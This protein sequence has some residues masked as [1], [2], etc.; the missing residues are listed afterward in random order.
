MAQTLAQKKAFKELTDR[1]AYRKANGDVNNYQVTI[2]FVNVSDEE[3]L[4]KTHLKAKAVR[5]TNCTVFKMDDS[6][7]SDEYLIRLRQNGHTIAVWRSVSH[8]WDYLNRRTGKRQ[9]GKYP[10]MPT[11]V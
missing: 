10:I 9:I 2:Q 4:Y 5:E 7:V 8:T 11:D 1:R 3:V 6:P